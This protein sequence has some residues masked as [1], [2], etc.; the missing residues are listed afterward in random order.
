MPPGDVDAWAA[1]LARLADDPV[2]RRR[3][4]AAGRERAAS[5]TAAH[6]A[7]ALVSAYRSVLA[8]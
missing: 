6:S 2:E 3:L 1:A 7:R 8:W 5:F 4:A